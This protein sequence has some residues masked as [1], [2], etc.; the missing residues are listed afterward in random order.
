MSLDNL[1]ALAKKRKEREGKG[2]KGGEA[3][4]AMRMKNVAAATQMAVK[5]LG[6]AVRTMINIR[7]F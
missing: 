2:V 4:L 7:G 5:V 1:C 3:G 6:E